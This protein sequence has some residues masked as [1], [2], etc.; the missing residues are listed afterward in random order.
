MKFHLTLPLLVVLLSAA[1]FARENNVSAALENNAAPDSHQG[2][3]AGNPEARRSDDIYVPLN[4]WIYPAL[5]RLAALGYINTQFTGLKP[6]TR[7]ECLRQAQEAE[8]SV[9]NLRADRSTA[10]TINRLIQELRPASPRSLELESLYAR[11]ETIGR[12]PVRDSYHFGQTIWN[13]FGR[14]YEEGE[15]ALVGASASARA[16]RFFLFVNGEYQH[17]PGR[18]AFSIAQRELIANLDANPVQPAMP[19]SDTN[20]FHLLDTYTGVQLGDYALTFGKQSLWLGPGETAPLM[21]S[22]NADP[23]YMLRFSRT[24]PLVL[25]GI[26][27]YLGPIRGEFLFSELEHHQFP[28]RPFFNLQK[29]SFH[30][31]KNLEVGFTRA[32]LWAGVGHPFTFGNLIR[33][34]TSLTSPEGPLISRNDPGDRKGGFDVSYRLPG[35]RRWLTFYLDSYSDDDPSPLASPRRA[36]INPGLYLSHFPAISK[37]DLRVE[38]VSTESLTAVD[39][40]G[41]FL[42]FNNQYHDANTNGGNLFGNPTGRDGRSYYGSSTY[43]FSAQSS[44]QFSYRDVK[45]STNFLPGGGTQNDG[46]ARLIWQASPT[47][48]I[49]TFVQVERWL[50]PALKPGVQHDVTGALQLTYT[51]HW[52]IV[53]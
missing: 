15:N 22:D 35:L 14:P 30:P 3:M 38:A 20:R 45:A 31:T 16:G 50:I 24:T 34:F 48:A 12:T 29:I 47:V 51:P 28:A 2:Q 23:M 39:R 43:H 7:T 8:S 32:S 46:A 18:D 9:R 37:L 40:T 11:T 26:F 17:A 4:S 6:W 21:L 33:N 27:R 5:E 52:R 44:L 41:Q 13:D 25:P 53:P 36:A 19:I 42:Y 10:D 1:V 49:D